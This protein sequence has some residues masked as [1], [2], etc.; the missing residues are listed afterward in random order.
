MGLETLKV[1][2]FVV[3]HMFISINIYSKIMFTIISV[4]QESIKGGWSNIWGGG[5]NFQKLTSEG[6]GLLFST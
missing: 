1:V 5:G 4:S 6:G 3:K 2:V